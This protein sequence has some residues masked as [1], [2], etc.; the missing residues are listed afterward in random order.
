MKRLSAFALAPVFAVVFALG[1][2]TLAAQT[3]LKS[4][5]KP[6]DKQPGQK[7][8]VI[9]TYGE[10][11]A[12]TYKEGSANTCYVASYPKKMEG[13]QSKP[14]EANILV[15]HWPSQKTFGVVSVTGGFDY[16]KDSTVELAIG[17]EK[18]SLF[19]QGSRG[20]AKEGEDPKIVKA[21]KSGKDAVASGVAASGTKTRDTFSLD[22]FTK[23]YEE[24]SKACGVKP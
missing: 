22:G 14:G 8:T 10:W 9:G 6:Q 2:S 1:A 12:I 19:T 13:H 7:A 20:W 3:Q 5:E 21:F 11:Q 18:F 16:K 15:T 24:A 17:D 4:A 23:A